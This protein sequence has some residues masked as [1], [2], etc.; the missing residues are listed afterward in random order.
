MLF[1][2]TLFLLIQCVSFIFILDLK[3]QSSSS[4]AKQMVIDSLINLSNKKKGIEK[5]EILEKVF[6]AQ[7][8]AFPKKASKTADQILDISQKTDDKKIKGKAAMVQ[9][10]RYLDI[11]KNHDST[12]FW[13]RKALSYF[14]P[15]KDSFNILQ[16][17][18]QM[19][20]SHLYQ[21]S[22][23]SATYFYIQSTKI[24]EAINAEAELLKSYSSLAN[25]YSTANDIK[26]AKFYNRKAYYLVKKTKDTLQQVK[27]CYNLSEDFFNDNQIDSAI[28]YSKEAVSLSEKIGFSMGI[29]RTLTQLSSYYYENKDAKKALQSIEK[30]VAMSDQ[31]NDS[32]FQF[33]VLYNYSRILVLNKLYKEAKANIHKTIVLLNVTTDN[34]YHTIIHKKNYYLLST[35]QSYL[36]QPD[37]AE[38]YLKKAVELSDKMDNKEVMDKTSELQTKYETEKKE[39]EIIKLNQERLINQ[40]ELRNSYYFTAAAILVGLIIAIII[41]TFFRQRNIINKFEKEQAKLRWRRAQINPHFFFNVLSAIQMLVY[42]KKTESAG[43]Y[44]IGFSYLM[45]QVL[46]GSNKERIS[47][48]EEIKFIQTYLDLE[49]I[50]LNFDYTIELN[51]EDMEIEDIFIPVMLLQP[52]V[53]NAIEHGL[54]K[55]NKEDKKLELQFVEI[56]Q[57]T[58]KISIKDNGAGRNQERKERHISRALEITKDRKKLM[59]DVFDYEII[60]HKDNNQNSLGTEV[61]FTIKI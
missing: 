20:T 22:Y 2:I 18:R 11:V 34:N 44:I 41:W 39:Q 59:K 6:D 52:F 61:V 21:G 13:S 19:A 30:V 48:E 37:S 53:E 31:V 12:L 16:V 40:L 23:D 36:N 10:L 49:K 45:R 9:I 32:R 57:H 4:N 42:E 50:S 7:Y 46:E 56:N 25:V 29:N 3:A 28:F 60:D 27:V 51:P 43:K 47:L 15:A 24:A 38:F 35:T 54:R 58:L 17:Y 14:E 8:Y 26:T 33:E 5:L 55:S 1:R